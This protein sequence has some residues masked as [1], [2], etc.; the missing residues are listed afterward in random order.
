ME[1][2]SYS[3]VNH[4]KRVFKFILYDIPGVLYDHEPDGQAY[5]SLP[6]LLYGMIGLLVIIAYFRE[7]FFGVAYNN[8]T[9]LVG[10]FSAA[11][12]GYVGKRFASVSLKKAESEGTENGE[13][14][15]V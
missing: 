11:A 13:K 4:I 12:A 8:M 14:T 2:I 1:K 7:H 9:N 5:L 15:D 3:P 6:R 10:F